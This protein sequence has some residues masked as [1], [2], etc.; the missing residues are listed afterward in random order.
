[1]K[2]IGRLSSAYTLEI[3]FDRVSSSELTSYRYKIPR[4]TT[5]R[6]DELRFL[7]FKNER[8]CLKVKS[9]MFIGHCGFSYKSS[10]SL[11]RTSI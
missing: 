6:I 4:A 7:D 1:M 2:V 5:G 9:R 3:R 8:L 10:R 11:C